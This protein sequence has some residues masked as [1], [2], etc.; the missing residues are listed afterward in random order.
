LQKQRG[1]EQI[2]QKQYRKG[3]CK[4]KSTPTL[5]TNNQA[6]QTGRNAENGEQNGI[7]RNKGLGNSGKE[8][9]TAKS[10]AAT[11]RKTAV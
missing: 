2:T 5:N 6:H 3:T 4:Q 10:T 9:I 1:E 8:A 7:G 11:A